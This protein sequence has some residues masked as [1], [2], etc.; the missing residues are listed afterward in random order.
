MQFLH[1]RNYY[2]KEINYVILLWD[3]SLKDNANR[4][5]NHVLSLQEIGIDSTV[6]LTEQLFDTYPFL[7][8]GSGVMQHFLDGSGQFYSFEHGIKNSRFLRQVYYTA[9][10][11]ASNP[12]DVAFSKHA[13]EHETFHDAVE[14]LRGVLMKRSVDVSFSPSVLSNSNLREKKIKVNR[15]IL[16]TG[17]FTRPTFRPS[18]YHFA[19]E[20]QAYDGGPKWK[21]R[22]ILQVAV[23]HGP[24]FA[25]LGAI[26]ALY[27]PDE[28]INIFDRPDVKENIRAMWPNCVIPLQ[29]EYHHG[30]TL[31]AL[32]N[33]LI[34]SAAQGLYPT[35]DPEKHREALDLLQQYGWIKNRLLRNE[36]EKFIGSNDTANAIAVFRTMEEVAQYLAS[37]S[38]LEP[39][40][41]RYLS[42]QFSRYGTTDLITAYLVIKPETRIQRLYTA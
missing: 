34:I 31:G 35:L 1:E 9:L 29:R 4:D 15:L 23:K 19:L 14:A 13:E 30:Q 11:R 16:S 37:N 40:R 27:T 17:E 32:Y 3:M 39:L 18:P 24:V 20:L 10:T 26:Y 33:I 28:I 6:G 2:S 41:S 22:Q 36:A 25:V 42:E 21:R 8:D 7:I 12:N 38:L 5:P